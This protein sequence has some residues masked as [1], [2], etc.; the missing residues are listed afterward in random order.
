MEH[1]G[2]YY[3]VVQTINPKGWRW[4]VELAPPLKNR[5]GVMLQRA[6]AVRRALGVINH[7]VLPT[8]IP[9]I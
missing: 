1:K 4:T 5:T 8:E 6:D 7:L 2:I 3:T 9:K